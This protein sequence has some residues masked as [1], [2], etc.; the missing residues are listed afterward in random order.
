MAKDK[1]EADL[2][3]KKEKKDKKRKREEAATE[4][5]PAKKEK[6]DKK[7]KSDAA[8]VE[9][10]VDVSMISAPADD[11]EDSQIVKS[12]VPLAALVP[13]AN[14]LADD[15]AQKK[16]LKGVKKGKIGRIPSVRSA[17]LRSREEQGPQARC[18][19]MCQGHPQV[20][21]RQP[22]NTHLL[23]RISFWYC[24]SRSRHLTNGRHQPYSCAL[25]GPQ[26]SIHLRPQPSRTRS[27]RQHKTTDQCRPHLCES[28][29]GC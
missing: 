9:A 2:R 19:G 1:S 27:S 11:V 26:H 16:V 29:Q 4:E 21:T 24:Y 3:E 14:P 17:D 6:K 10:N 18:E 28:W 8:D 25:R 23:K 13:F 7:R 15:K 12:E 5:A 20:T 22:S